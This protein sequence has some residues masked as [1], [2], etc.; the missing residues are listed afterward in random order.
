[1]TYFSKVSVACGAEQHSRKP[2]EVHATG[3]ESIL[4]AWGEGQHLA[5]VCHIQL[6]YFVL[7]AEIYNG[8][9]PLPSGRWLLTETA[10]PGVTPPGDELL[11]RSHHSVGA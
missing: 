6:W 4:Q 3:W 8:C 2:T 9:P 10:T 7:V 11:C 1:M 5:C